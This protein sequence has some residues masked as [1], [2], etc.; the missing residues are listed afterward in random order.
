MSSPWEPPRDGRDGVETPAP[1]APDPR[2]APHGSRPEPYSSS[3]FEPSPYALEPY[4]D[5][6]AADRAAGH[7][8]YGQV[9]QPYGQQYGQTPYGQQYGSAPYGQNPYASTPHAT[10]AP[11]PSAPHGGYG[12]PSAS[13]P[14]TSG[15]AV[16]ALVCGILG[17]FTAGLASIAAVICGHLAWRDTGS[18]RYAGHGMTIAGLVLGYLPIIGWIAF[19]LFFLVVGLGTI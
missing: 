7:D 18:G 15:L 8:P 11:Y 1:S 17:F 4:S 13:G 12:P 3:A 16:A 2:D 9:P 14:P 10:P 19:W 6:Y 5:P